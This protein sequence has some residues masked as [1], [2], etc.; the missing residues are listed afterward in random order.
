MDQLPEGIGAIA[1][2]LGGLLLQ[3]VIDEDGAEC[4]VLPLVG[5][6]GFGEEAAAESVIHNGGLECESIL[7]RQ[8]PFEGSETRGS[9]QLKL[10]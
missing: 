2:A 9:C 4:L 10:A 1:E 8:L 3:A 5:R 7:L 6:D